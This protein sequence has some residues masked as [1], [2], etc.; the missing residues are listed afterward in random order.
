[1]IDDYKALIGNEVYKPHYDQ[2]TGEMRVKSFIIKEI[3]LCISQDKTIIKYFMTNGHIYSI[4]EI[5]VN[6]QDAKKICTE[7][8][9]KIA[10]AIAL[11]I[12]AVVVPIDPLA[13]NYIENLRQ[14]ARKIAEHLS[15]SSGS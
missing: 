8:N 13:E 14:V 7:F 12:D 15:G 10:R 6:E 9:T 5:F 1:M 4:H 3:T 11:Q 2:N